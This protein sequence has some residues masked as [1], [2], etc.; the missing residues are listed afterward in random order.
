MSVASPIP[1]VP[2]LPSFRELGSTLAESATRLTTRKPHHA[3]ISS[4]SSPASQ[5]PSPVGDMPGTPTRGPS[6]RP[7]VD[8]LTVFS[9]ATPPGTSAFSVVHS[10]YSDAYA[11]MCDLATAS[12][13]IGRSLRIVSVTSD[14]EPPSGNALAGSRASGVVQTED[15]DIIKLAVGLLTLFPFCFNSTDCRSDKW[16]LSYLFLLPLGRGGKLDFGAGAHL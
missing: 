9:E 2:S 15:A 16:H 8:H 14:L 11:S 10:R 3:S 1:R 5:S 6:P 4:F 13:G 7:L 12:P